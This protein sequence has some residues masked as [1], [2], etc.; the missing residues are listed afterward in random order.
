[1]KKGSYIQNLK[2]Y[3]GNFYIKGVENHFGSC[4]LGSL[5]LQ[6]FDFC[7][8]VEKDYGRIEERSMFV[9]KMPKEMSQPVGFQDADTL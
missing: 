3:Q 2:E 5:K 8:S 4:S 6:A 9:A 1:M 7:Q